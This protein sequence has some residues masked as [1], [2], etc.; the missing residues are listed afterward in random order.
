MEFK[1]PLL[2]RVGLGITQRGARL[3]SNGRKEKVETEAEEQIYL[4]AV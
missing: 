1:V 3:R 4:D 2:Y